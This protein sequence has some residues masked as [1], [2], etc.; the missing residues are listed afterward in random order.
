MII[1]Y[2]ILLNIIF[3][4]FIY[5]VSQRASL[6]PVWNSMESLVINV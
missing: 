5:I 3:C 1:L 4:S 2:I 6:V